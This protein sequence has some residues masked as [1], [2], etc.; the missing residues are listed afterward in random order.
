MAGGRSNLTDDMLITLITSI[1][2][3]EC[4]Y[5]GDPLIVPTV[6]AEILYPIGKFANVQIVRSDE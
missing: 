5:N 3:I 1:T 2:P 6:I 4:E